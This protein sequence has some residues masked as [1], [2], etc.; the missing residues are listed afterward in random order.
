MAFKSLVDLEIS[1]DHG[2]RTSTTRP[3]RTR[4]DDRKPPNR[5]VIMN[6]YT[7]KL[8]ADGLAADRHHQA[9][10]YRRSRAAARS[11]ADRRSP[12]IR[13]PRPPRP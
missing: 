9:D 3:E 1:R 12:R 4:R 7:A 11:S 8:L 2:C 6:W 13:L 10:R 5:S